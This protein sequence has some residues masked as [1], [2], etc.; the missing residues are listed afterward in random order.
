MDRFV[1]ISRFLATMK[2]NIVSYFLL[3]SMLYFTNRVDA[4][5][6]GAGSCNTGVAV[7]GPHLS[8]TPIKTGSLE[9]GNFQ[10]ATNGNIVISPHLNITA[11][12][13]ASSYQLNVLPVSGSGATFRGVLIRVEGP[14]DFTITPGSNAQV[15]A[16]CTDDGVFGVTHTDNTD[17]VEFG[18][19]FRTESEGEYKI[20]V[21]VVVS[22]TATTGSTHYYNQFVLTSFQEIPDFPT[23]TPILTNS[24]VSPVAAKA[25]V[26][27]VPIGTPTA[28]VAGPISVPVPAAISVPT[29]AMPS[30]AAIVVPTVSGPVTTE[31]SVTLVPS[32][33]SVPSKTTTMESDVPSDVETMAPTDGSMAPIIATTSVPVVAPTPVRVPVAPVASVPTPVAST[34]GSIENI[35]RITNVSLLLVTIMSMMVL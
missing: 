33:T 29:T 18:S 17:K 10:L 35:L 7:G 22:N 19:T 1:A 26:A 20:E 9:D 2:I 27:T 34:S 3:S 13:P 11:I 30:T 32:L 4:S 14:G 6:T 8:Y 15:A 28:P 16:L 23:K 5:P 21:T 24:T 31:P 25:L 12:Q